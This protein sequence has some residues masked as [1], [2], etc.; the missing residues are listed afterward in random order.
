MQRES[1]WDHGRFFFDLTTF[2][3]GV[4]VLRRTHTKEFSETVIKGTC[5]TSLQLCYEKKENF[6][7]WQSEV[8]S[9]KCCWLPDPVFQALV[10]L[11]RKP[12]DVAA[13]INQLFR[14]GQPLQQKA[15]WVTFEF[16]GPFS[17]MVHLF[18]MTTGCSALNKGPWISSEGPFLK[19]VL[20]SPF[21]LHEQWTGKFK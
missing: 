14:A 21:W 3:W 6:A 5:F 4:T 1:D 12:R 2:C 15:R 10:S 16:G 7:S 19:M 8:T 20:D 11:E 9:V 17:F 13:F 18:W